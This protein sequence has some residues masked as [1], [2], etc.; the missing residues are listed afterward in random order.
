MIICNDASA[1]EIK[2]AEEAVLAI[3]PNFAKLKEH[4]TLGEYAAPIFN[5]KPDEGAFVLRPLLFEAIRSKAA[6]LYGAGVADGVIAQLGAQPS[7]ETGV[8]LSAPHTLDGPGKGGEDSLLTW[9]SV[10]F[11][12]GLYQARGLSYHIS[13]NTGA[14]SFANINSAKYIQ[15]GAD[16]TLYTA[17]KSRDRGTLGIFKSAMSL[18]EIADMEKNMRA[19]TSS[20]PED[21]RRIAG[22]IGALE[23]FSGASYADQISAVNAFL[24]DEVYGAKIGSRP[25]VRQVTLELTG[26]LNDVLVRGLESG[27][28][29]IRK[30]FADRGN[31]DKFVSELG[32]IRAAWNA[33]ESPFMR[34]HAGSCLKKQP[35]E[36]AAH[37]PGN[38]VEQIRQGTW[39]PTAGLELVL[40]A[41]GGILPHGGIY[42]AGYMPQIQA[43]LVRYL[44]AIG[45]GRLGREIA[46]MDTTIAT[47]SPIVAMDGGVPMSYSDLIA[48][49]V[50]APKMLDAIP[51]LRARDAY[52]A[53]LPY[54]YHIITHSDKINGQKVGSDLS[55]AARERLYA[56][57]K[58]SM[59][60]PMLDNAVSAVLIKFAMNERGAR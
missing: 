1:G 4:E 24:M 53:A 8:H 58:H 48:K 9:Q 33:G 44:G 30:I 27:N 36:S 54:M 47:M 26:I 42:Q 45:E 43:S 31:L 3:C 25:K 22:I 37:V 15:A 59:Q 38:I 28:P 11:S 51:R 2:Y 46:K 12:A 6:Q 16:N 57:L 39:V 19:K 20:A 49:P 29:I 10:V 5:F 41:L 7:A 55:L 50:D 17:I 21:E 60:A 35:Y 13:L 56:R 18:S 34:Y 52:D 14:V 32:G 40:L 23:K